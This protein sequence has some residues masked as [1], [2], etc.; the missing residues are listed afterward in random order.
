MPKLSAS[1]PCRA[2]SGLQRRH[3][4]FL[5]AYPNHFLDREKEYLPVADFPCSC[6]PCDGLHNSI[7]QLVLDYDFQLYLGQE[8]DAVFMSVIC[9]RMTLLPAVS[10]HFRG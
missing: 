8:I 7:Y 5:I 2:N 10:T 4:T 1:R 3:A 6:G 9:L